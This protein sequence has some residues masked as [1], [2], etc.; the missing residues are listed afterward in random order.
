VGLDA[1]KTVV[2]A[3]SALTSMPW[4]RLC[5]IWS[6][7]REDSCGSWV[8]LAF[9]L[10]SSRLARHVGYRSERCEGVIGFVSPK[11]IANPALEFLRQLGLFGLSIEIA[12]LQPGPIGRRLRR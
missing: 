7:D 2:L 12:L 6:R 9:R 3:C 1:G 11:K 4:A 5:H 8:S 10:K